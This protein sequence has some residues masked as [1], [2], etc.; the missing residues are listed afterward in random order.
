MKTKTELLLEAL[1]LM[2]ELSWASDYSTYRRVE[3]ELAEVADELGTTI[4][5]LFASA[6]ILSDLEE[7]A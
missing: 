5:G 7:A 6:R 1:G 3:E 2:Q 4:E